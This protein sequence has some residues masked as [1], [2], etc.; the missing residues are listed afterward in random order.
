MTWELSEESFMEIKIEEFHCF[1]KVVSK[2][3][4]NNLPIVII[5]TLHLLVHLLEQM[6]SFPVSLAE[7]NG[8]NFC[9]FS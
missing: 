4:R 9:T 5:L 3:K 2:Q 8:V 1:T 7:V 6:E